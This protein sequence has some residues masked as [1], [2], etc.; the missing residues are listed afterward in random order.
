MKNPY[1]MISDI[2]IPVLEFKSLDDLPNRFFSMVKDSVSNL[3]GSGVDSKKDKERVAADL[4][5]LFE[6]GT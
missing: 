3:M 6:D 1:L 5:A 4:G 2:R